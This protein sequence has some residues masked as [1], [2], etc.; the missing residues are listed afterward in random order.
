MVCVD[1]SYLLDE[2]KPSIYNRNLR[3]NKLKAGVHVFIQIN[4]Y[5]A[6]GMLYFVIGVSFYQVY[7]LYYTFVL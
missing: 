5:S 3:I 2:A 1:P 7:I 6:V 4:P